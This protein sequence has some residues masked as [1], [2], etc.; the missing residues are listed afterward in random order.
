[1]TAAVLL[2]ELTQAG[3]ELLADGDKLRYRPQ[4]AMTPDLAERLGAHKAEIL[5]L[6]QAGG[7]PEAANPAPLVHEPDPPA[8]SRFAGWVRR[9]DCRGRMGWELPRLPEAARWWARCEF[10]DLPEPPRPAYSRVGVA[11]C[12]W[13]GR[14]A[15]WRSVHGV[16]VCGNCHP[17]ATPGLVAEWIG[18][19]SN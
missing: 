12:P 7:R 9:P 16:V 2:A 5:S 17:P 13:C 14:F 18:E 19:P 3:I 15:W 11:P 8:G 1:M 10:D 6:L 4:S